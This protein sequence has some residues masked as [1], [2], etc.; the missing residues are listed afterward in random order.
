MPQAYFTFA[1]RIFHSKDI[2]LVPEEQISLKALITNQIFISKAPSLFII[3]Y[4]L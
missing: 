3:H 2:S 1:K 4:S